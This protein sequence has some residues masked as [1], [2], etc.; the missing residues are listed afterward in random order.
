MN[1]RA[2]LLREHSARQTRRLTEYACAH[3]KYFA[4]LL[5]VFWYGTPRERQLAADVL[6][7]A[8]Q[9]R[10]AWLVPHLAGLLAAAQPDQTEQHPAVRRS[11]VRVLQFV[12]VP[13]EWQALTYDLCLGLLVAPTELVAIRGYALSAATRLAGA[14]PELATELLAA[15]ESVLSTATSA[16]LHS[17]AAREMPKLRSV[18]RDVLPG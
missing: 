18:I 15:I 6:G 2:E 9:Q 5:R 13:E 1:L 8:G 7:M 10:P 11:V 16:A 17:R 3:P 14:Y 12:A 4:E